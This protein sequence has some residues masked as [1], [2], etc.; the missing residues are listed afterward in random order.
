M[1]K[2]EYN[3][4]TLVPQM[5][6]GESITIQSHGYKMPGHFKITAESGYLKPEGTLIETIPGNQTKTFDV[7]I[8]EKIQVTVKDAG[9]IPYYEG[10][11]T[12]N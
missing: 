2:I 10:E 11:F 7:A 3:E 9:T 1:V 12:I 4:R 5:Q 6:S 8:Y